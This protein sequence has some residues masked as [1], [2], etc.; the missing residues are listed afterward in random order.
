VVVAA[1]GAI[2]LASSGGSEDSSSLP[3][4]DDLPARAVAVVVGVPAG[5]EAPLERPAEDCDGKT[6]TQELG[7]ITEA[8]LDCAIDQAAANG[9]GKT[10]EPGGKEYDELRETALDSLLETV[11]I[12]GLA[13]EEGISVTQREI[14][15]ELEKIAADNFES[16]AELDEFLETSHLSDRDVEERVKVQILSSELLEK[17]Q[18]KA[19]TEEKRQTALSRYARDFEERWRSRTVCSPAVATEK[20]SNGERKPEPKAEGEG[21]QLSGVPPGTVPR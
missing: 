6:A 16:D 18:G 12:Q 20:C 3:A 2:L 21:D 5:A 15:V 9:N 13:S 19:A 1:A 4:P 11:W 14:E 10:P 17:A 8:E 7:T